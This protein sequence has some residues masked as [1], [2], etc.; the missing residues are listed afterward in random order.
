[1]EE[2]KGLESKLVTLGVAR[3]RLEHALDGVDSA[4]SPYRF[5]IGLIESAMGAD[6]AVVDAR[7]K[8]AMM[9]QIEEDATTCVSKAAISAW[10]DGLTDGKKEWRHGNWQIRLRTTITPVVTHVENFI[11]HLV[12]LGASRIV[13]RITLNR[14]ATTDL[15]ATVKLTGLEIEEKT[16]CSVKCV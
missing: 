14:K 15:N 7:E 16:T 3:E 1:M 5:A 11:A 8:L 12:E 9:R 10:R 2:V 13:R 4:E 6:R